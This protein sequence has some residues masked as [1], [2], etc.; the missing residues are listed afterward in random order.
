MISVKTSGDMDALPRWSGIVV[1]GENW[2]KCPVDGTDVW[3][4]PGHAETVASEDLLLRANGSYI[5]VSYRPDDIE[6][7]IN[8]LRPEA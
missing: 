8:S 7:F 5:S 6:I 2:L 3:C 4:S 1:L